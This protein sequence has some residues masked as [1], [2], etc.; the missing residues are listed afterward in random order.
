MVLCVSLRRLLDVLAMGKRVSSSGG[1]SAVKKA[2]AKTGPVPKLPHVVKITDWFFGSEHVK[3]KFAV[4]A[5]ISHKLSQ[6]L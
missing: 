4:V 5:W 3:I 6:C 1:G 2:N